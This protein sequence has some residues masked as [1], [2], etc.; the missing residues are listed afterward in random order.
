VAALERRSV[1]FLNQNLERLW[2]LY[3]HSRPECLFVGRITQFSALRLASL[4]LLVHV[5]TQFVGR[6]TQF[7]AL[8][9][10]SLTFLVHVL[11][12]LWVALLS[13]SVCVTRLPPI[14]SFAIHLPFIVYS[15]PCISYCCLCSFNNLHSRHSGSQTCSTGCGDVI[16]LRR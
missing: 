6:I 2:Q 1:L 10:A 14:T 12:S 8:R 13:L 7:S 9:L 11:L 16:V 5:F 4:T 3:Y 15:C